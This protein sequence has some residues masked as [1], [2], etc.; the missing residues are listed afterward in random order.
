MRPNL[1]VEI[2]A[3]RVAEVADRHTNNGVMLDQDI[4]FFVRLPHGR[5]YVEDTQDFARERS[6]AEV[7]CTTEIDLNIVTIDLIQQVCYD[8]TTND[9]NVTIILENVGNREIDDLQTR[10]IGFEDR[11]PYSP[12]FNIS[13]GAGKA[14]LVTWIHDFDELGHIAQVSMSPTISLGGKDV[15]CSGNQLKLVDIKSCEEVFD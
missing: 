3:V 6:D 13:I 4:G 1:G 7:V 8:N 9:Y 15:V 12:E 14:K 10:V 2:E 5:G 11:V